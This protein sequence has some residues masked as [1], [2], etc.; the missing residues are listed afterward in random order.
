M[1]RAGR[2]CTG[3]S[4]TFLPRRRT[5]RKEK[6]QG[7]VEGL[8]NGGDPGYEGPGPRYFRGTHHYRFLVYA[9]DAPLGLPATADRDAVAAAME[10][11]VLESA[12]LVG[13]CTSSPA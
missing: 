10:G 11:H 7:G 12:E 2:G 8:A 1:L 5:W 13:I 6:P 9:L 4:S 3:W